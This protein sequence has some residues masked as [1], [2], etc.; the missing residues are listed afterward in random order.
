MSHW[1]GARAAAVELLRPGWG[2]MGEVNAGTV[3]WDMEAIRGAPLG[4]NSL[5]AGLGAC[6]RTRYT[7]RTLLASLQQLQESFPQ[8]RD[9][10]SNIFTNSTNVLWNLFIIRL[11]CDL[12][13]SNQTPFF[14]VFKLGPG[15]LFIIIKKQ[16]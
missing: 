10:Q 6:K 9:V 2:K 8:A 16:K 14:W 13:D 3:V 7:N 1:P 12:S 5:A 15:Y 4:T 11:V